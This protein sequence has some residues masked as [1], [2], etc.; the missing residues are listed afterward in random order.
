MNRT[1]GGHDL[2][3][4]SNEAATSVFS[5]PQY[6]GSTVPSFSIAADD[7]HVGRHMCWMGY[8]AVGATQDVLYNGNPDPWTSDAEF[9]GIVIRQNEDEHNSILGQLRLIESAAE[10][11]SEGALWGTGDRLSVGKG[12]STRGGLA[13][14]WPG[15]STTPIF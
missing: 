13:V 7:S 4:G 15:S 5:N 9:I 2:C 6:G 1:G 14:P 11:V 3:K 12:T 8:D 10:Y